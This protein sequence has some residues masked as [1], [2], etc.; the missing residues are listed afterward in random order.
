MCCSLA[1]QSVVR[2]GSAPAA[3]REHSVFYSEGVEDS[4]R[5]ARANCEYT[6]R[7]ILWEAVYE[8]TRLREHLPVESPDAE[9]IAKTQQLDALI[10]SLNGDFVDIVTHP[11][12]NYQGLIALHVRNH[13]KAVP[14]LMQRLRNYFSSHPDKEYY[15]YKSLVVEVHRI[16]VRQ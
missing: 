11:P 13:P 12:A 8:V 9:V 3:E 6:G 5:L 14:H 7:P 2:G 16:R 15:R 4:C 1:A 10:L